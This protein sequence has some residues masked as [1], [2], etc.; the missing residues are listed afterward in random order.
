MVQAKLFQGLLFNGLFGKLFT[1]SKSSKTPREFILMKDETLLWNN[2]NMYLLL[3]LDPSLDSPK[4]VCIN[5]SM[6]DVVAASVGL[7]RSI[8][9]EDKQNLTEILN[10]D[11]NDGDIIHLANKS[12]KAGDVRNVVVLAFHT[13]KLYTALEVVD[14]SANSTF[15]GV[16]VKKG[17]AF[18]TFAEYFEKKYAQPC[19]CSYAHSR[20][21]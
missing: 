19:A 1:G 18:R 4:R 2:A 16:S 15:D 7:M 17:P 20:I 6:I 11:K 10:L 5:W 9:S 14:K 21:Y 3:P 13:G 12:C 8:Y